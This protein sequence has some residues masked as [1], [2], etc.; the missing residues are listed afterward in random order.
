MKKN[1]H[2]TIYN[3]LDELQKNC[4][5]KTE[6]NW[7]KKLKEKT[8]QEKRKLKTLSRKA[9][10]E[11]FKEDLIKLDNIIFDNKLFMEKLTRFTNARK[12][13]AS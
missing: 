6:L 13:K 11:K 9:V 2:K 3:L 10:F 4:K 5:T 7:I 12:R 1:D 8:I